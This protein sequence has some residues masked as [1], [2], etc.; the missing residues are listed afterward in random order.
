MILEILYWILFILEVRAQPGIITLLAGSGPSTQTGDGGLATSATLDNPYGLY[1]NGFQVYIS[2]PPQDN[3]RLVEL[4]SKTISTFSSVNNYP[5]SVMVYDNYLWIAMKSS[6]KIRKVDLSTAAI[7][8]VAGDGTG[9]YTG[10]GGNALLARLKFPFGVYIDSTYIWIGDTSNNVIRQVTRSSNTIV[11]YAG[12]GPG[13][14]TYNGDNIEGTAACF[15][16]LFV[17]VDSSRVWITDQANNRIRVVSRSTR[18]ITTIAGTGG[19]GAYFGDNGNPISAKFNVLDCVVADAAYVWMIDRNN[20][21]IRR[22]DLATSIITTFVGTGNNAYSG[23]GGYCTS[24]EIKSS[25]GLHVASNYMYFNDANRVRR[26]RLFQARLWGDPH[27]IGLSGGS[28]TIDLTAGRCYNIYRSSSFRW[29]SCVVQPGHRTS[30]FLGTSTFQMNSHKV[31]IPLP[32]KFF[33]AAVVDGKHYYKLG[34]EVRLGPKSSFR[35]LHSSIMIKTPCMRIFMQLRT[36][37]TSIRKG[38]SNIIHNY[39]NHFD[40]TLSDIHNSI[41]CSPADGLIGITWNKTARPSGRHGEG[42]IRGK[43]SDYEISDVWD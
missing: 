20:Y 5:T 21:R 15:D 2:Q 31:L 9:S 28:Y 17:F 37:I 12:V 32:K 14:N 11:T 40:F 3:I 43:F 18:T 16:P 30:T 27:F 34:Q 41:G 7:S 1:V 42:V 36:Q 33:V 39:H 22:I 4:S 23:D 38:K 29:N 26:V 10:D 8:D 35:I 25:Y 6:H 13:N 24:A 19:A